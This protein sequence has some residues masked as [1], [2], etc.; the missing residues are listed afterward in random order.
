VDP[1]SAPAPSGGA[2]GRVAADRKV[3]AGALLA[4]WLIRALGASVRKHHHGDAELRRRKAAGE[5]VILAFWHRH[6]LLMPFA[7]GQG[8]ITVLISLHRDGE[9]IARTVARLGIDST[10]GSTSRG[11]VAGVRQLLRKGRRGFDLAFTPDGPRGP[12]AEVQPG[13]VVAAALTGFPIQPIA[14]AASR[15]RRLASW[16]R[17]I[18]PW[19]FSTVHFVYAEPLSVPRGGDVETHAGLLKARLDAA[20]A[21]A[22]RLASRGGGRGEP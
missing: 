17:F 10:R 15:C 2:D 1:A 12:A 18:V 5:R 21:E 19:P 22:E 6:L 8:R 16:D 11:A 20:E 4:A 14:Y 3:A 7:Y 13:V 9:L